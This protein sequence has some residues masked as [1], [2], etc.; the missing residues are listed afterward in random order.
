MLIMQKVH[1]CLFIRE[2]SVKEMNI[3]K[4]SFE[5]LEVINDRRMRPS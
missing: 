5:V 1:I 3:A 2:K 4:E